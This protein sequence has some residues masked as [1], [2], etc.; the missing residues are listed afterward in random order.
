MNLTKKKIIF[1]RS[2]AKNKLP[3]KKKNSTYFFFR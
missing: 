3:K 1:K 2:L